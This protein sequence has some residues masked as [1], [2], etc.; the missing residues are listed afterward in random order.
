[1]Q[2]SKYHTRYYL[3]TISIV[4]DPISKASPCLVGQYILQILEALVVVSI[5]VVVGINM[6][7]KTK[8]LG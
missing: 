4:N 5:V 6:T 2:P 7:T 3:S 8:G 1:M